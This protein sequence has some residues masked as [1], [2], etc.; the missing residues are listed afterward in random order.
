MKKFFY[1]LSSTV[2]LF[3]LAVVIFMGCEGPAGPAGMDANETCKMCHNSGSVLLAKQV[4]AGN[5]GHQTGGNFERSANDCAA[6]HTNEGF[7]DRMMSGLMEAATDIE[8]PTPPNCRT[9]HMIHENYDTTDWALRFTDPVTLWIND[10]AVDYGNGNVCANCH[11]PRL[12]D[13]YPVSGGADVSITSSRWGPHHGPQAA[14]LYGTSAYEI[15]GDVSYPAAGSHAHAGAG[16]TQCHMAVVEEHGNVVGGHTL[17]MTFLYHGAMEDNVAGCLSCHTS[18]E[19]F[20]L[21]D[22]VTEITE[23]FDSLGSVLTGKGY[24]KDGSVN[25]SSDSP[26][27][28]NPD[29]AGALLNYQYVKEDKS[30]GVHNP[31]YITALLKNSLQ[32][33]TK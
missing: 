6:C 19:D 3:L 16:C 5:S 14:V 8:N 18:I 12:I 13:P 26:L 10:V 1:L 28:L 17:N 4:Q 23:L 24:L 27:V 9:C 25:A 7:L 32:H 21:H 31:A 11:Q 33:L 30:M 29:D 15:A 2:G 20:D 22:Q